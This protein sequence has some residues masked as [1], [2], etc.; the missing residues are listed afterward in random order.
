V[1]E[2]TLHSRLCESNPFD[3]D[4]QREEYEMAYALAGHICS[5]DGLSRLE[6]D[7]AVSDAVAAVFDALVKALGTRLPPE[8]AFGDDHPPPL[9]MLDHREEIFEVCLSQA[10]TYLYG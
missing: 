10:R 7:C 2:S 6:A 5:D 3:W 9:V 4:T 1:S 8:E